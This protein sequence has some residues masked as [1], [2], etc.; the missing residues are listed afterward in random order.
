[1]EINDDA[2]KVFRTYLE[3]VWPY[4]E[5]TDDMVREQIELLLVISVYNETEKYNL[6]TSLE[7]L[8]A[9]YGIDTDEPTMEEEEDAQE[10]REDESELKEAP[11]SEEDA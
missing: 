6:P 9:Y 5:V 8:Y 2:V 3:E 1:M 7:A 4:A 10:V 11:H